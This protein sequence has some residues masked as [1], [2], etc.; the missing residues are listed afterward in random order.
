MYQIDENL[1]RI[2]VNLGS[3]CNFRCH[4]CFENGDRMEYVPT[5]TS[6]KN[7]QRL[8]EYLTWLKTKKYPDYRFLITIFGGEPLLQLDTMTRF[9][10]CVSPIASCINFTTNG[11]LVPKYKD[12]ILALTRLKNGAV[13][14][15]GVSYDFACQNEARCAGTYESVRDAIR[16]LYH[17]GVLNKTLTVVS[18]KNLHRLHEIFFDF[19]ELRK[20]LPKLEG[21]FNTDRLD[22]FS[23]IDE[24]AVRA[25]LQQIRDYTDSGHE[26]KFY[27]NPNVGID[28][29]FLTLKG[30]FFSNILLGY[31]DD[32]VLYPAYDVPYAGETVEKLFR[33]GHV[34]EP[35][36]ELDAKREAMLAKIPDTFPEVCKTCTGP[37]R[38]PAWGVVKDSFD[39]WWD[40][41]P[42]GQC[43]VH[44]LIGEYLRVPEKH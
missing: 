36:E 15:V 44:R 40:M 12:R 4:Y 2:E 14:K 27:F 18:S 9:I 10:R 21:T 32:G 34:S 5:T 29:G 43:K 22:D 26:V 13:V 3:L 1:V 41:P 16:W 35:F 19:E 31:A 30:C 37:C 24:A 7:L 20:E 6:W 17:A 8:A 39:Q 11:V 42:E 25:S 38:M 28:R 33:I 23:T